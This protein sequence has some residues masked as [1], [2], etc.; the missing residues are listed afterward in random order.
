VS[1]PTVSVL[2]PTYNAARYLAEAIESILQQTW[3]DLQLVVLDGGSTDPTEDIVRAY[4]KR[5]DRIKFESFPDRHPCARLDEYIPTLKSR[6]IAIQHADDVSYRNRIA[7][8]L[9]A[10][11]EDSDLSVCSVL[12]K[13][14]AHQRMQAGIQDGTYIHM[15]PAAHAAIKAN[16]PFWWVMHCPTYM[17]D[18]E[19]ITRAGMKFSNDYLYC[20]DYWQTVTHIDRL[21]YHNIQ[22]PLAAYRLH[23]DSDG[24]KN[25]DRVRAE[26]R[27]IKTESLRHFGFEFT[28]RE[29]EIHGAFRMLPDGILDAKTPED[30]EEILLWL[31][32]LKEQNDD[33]GVFDRTEFADLAEN[34]ED[35]TRQKMNMGAKATGT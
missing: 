20:N 11:V 6:F 27:K 24:L 23:V 14:F 34:L 30:F 26:E 1:D 5:D 12:V 35:L 7:R 28:P 31:K 33:L 18:R 13:S 10:F 16:L 25:Q 8:Q 2:M 15:R 32:K 3:K 19:K 29:A 22:E 21:K 9:R 17:F 4:A